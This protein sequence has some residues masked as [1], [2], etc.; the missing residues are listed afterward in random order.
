M[1]HEPV[2]NYYDGY[3]EREWDR[4]KRPDDG[5]VEY[6]VTRKMLSKYLKP[7]SRILD[8]GGGPGRYA[9]WLAKHGHRVVLADLSPE[10]LTIA[11]AKLAEAG[12]SVN[13]EE[14]IEVDACDL[15]HWKNDSFDAVLSL[16]PFYH[17]IDA[18][19]RE[20]A[21]SELRRV[22]KPQGVDFI[23][24]IPR[25][26]FLRHALEVPDLRHNLTHPEFVSRVLEQGVFTNDIPGHFT[27]GYGF[28]TAEVPAFFAQRGFTMQTLLAAEGIVGD[29][30]R[31]L[32]ELDQNDPVTYQAALDLILRTADD[33]GILGM[34]SHLLY[35]GKKEYTS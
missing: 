25:Y 28:R 33:P 9:M 4:L 19:D 26:S 21:L 3:G 20:K 16:G 31:V 32:F 18:N 35:I 27:N 30:Q 34:A 12:V 2:K 22:L 13:I 14:I 29:L 17:L 10:L 5:F 1:T 24:L 8:I 15:S 23:A 7:N 6:A 11:H